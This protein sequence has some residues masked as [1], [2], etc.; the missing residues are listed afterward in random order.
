MRY[1]LS[2]LIMMANIIGV[3]GAIFRDRAMA[4]MYW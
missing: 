1:R 2:L 4:V 3:V